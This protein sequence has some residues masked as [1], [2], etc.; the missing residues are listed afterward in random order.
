MAA[1]ETIWVDRNGI[2]FNAKENSPEDLIFKIKALVG[3]WRKRWSRDNLY[4]ARCYSKSRWGVHVRCRF[5]HLKD[6]S[7]AVGAC[8]RCPFHFAMQNVSLI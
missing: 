5:G 7:G 1:V 2:M 6:L 3:W 8:Q 4:P